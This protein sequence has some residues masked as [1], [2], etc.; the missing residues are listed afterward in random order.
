MKNDS[1][2]NAPPVHHPTVWIVMPAYNEAERIEETLQLVT[3]RGWNVIL[4]DDGSDDDTATV[5][6]RFPIW[7]LRHPINCGQGAALK[8][9]IDFALNKGAEV[10]VT[11]DSDGQHDVQEIPQ[12]IS[13][14]LS[15]DTDVAL[16]S[17]FLGEARDMPWTRWLTLKLAI[18]FTRLTSG[19]ILTDAHNG[20]RAFSRRSC[21]QIRIQQPRMAHASEIVEEIDRLN[22]RFVEIPVAITYRAETLAKGQSSLGALRITGHLLAG[23]IWK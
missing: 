7:V 23:R 15:G 4:V 18:L 6:A 5:A 10:I 9:G 14:V 8:T 13:P 11:F 16:G 2:I 12:I 17:R 20:F 19:L 1:G 21:Q 22:L 3:E